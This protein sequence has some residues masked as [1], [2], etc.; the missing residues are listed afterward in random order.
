MNTRKNPLL[1]TY[2]TQLNVNPQVYLAGKIYKDCWRHRLVSNLRQHTWQ[3]R[4]LHQENFD[5]NGPFFV[6]C[7][8]GCYHQPS[9]HGNKDGCSEDFNLQSHDVVDK[10]LTAVD[11]SDLV[12]CFIDA[13]DCYGTIAEIQRAHDKGI[14]VVIAFAPGIADKYQNDFWFICTKAHKVHFNICECKLRQLF[15]QTLVEMIQ[16]T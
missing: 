16:W 8:H 13:R 9:S 3:D 15:T 7:D 4:P 5:Y 12:F 11:S 1:A 2:F 6:G 10:C 14:R